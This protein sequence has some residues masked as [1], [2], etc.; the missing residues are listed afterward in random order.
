MLSTSVLRD[1][2]RSSYTSSTIAQRVSLSPPMGPSLK[3][4]GTMLR[5]V[6]SDRNDTDGTISPFLNETT[7][8]VVVL[9]PTMRF[10]RHLF[11]RKGRDQHHQ[12]S[13]LDYETTEALASV[14][15]GNPSSNDDPTSHNNE[16]IIE[17]SMGP[18][19]SSLLGVDWKLPVF[20]STTTNEQTIEDEL[21]R[22]IALQSYNLLEMER[23]EVFDRITRLAAE[24][25]ET[26]VA[27]INL[28]DLSRTWFVSGHGTGEDRKSVV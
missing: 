27:I 22:L 19:N 5:S 13:V 20:D 16:S 2:D 1:K 21:Q 28:V 26:P 24:V 6:E 17:S 9:H 11:R 18:N 4:P 25:F 23:A 14:L 8:S 10:P 7:S 15:A 3:Q 12:P